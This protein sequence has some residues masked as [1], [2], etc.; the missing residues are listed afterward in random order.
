MG[1]SGGGSGVIMD[2]SGIEFKVILTPKD[3]R[4]YLVTLEGPLGKI[5]KRARVSDE[6]LAVGG[7][8]ISRKLCFAIERSIGEIACD[9]MWIMLKENPACLPGVVSRFS[10]VTPQ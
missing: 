1:A 4:E 2:K 6:E 9:F 8:P 10:S 3:E 7:A 5:H